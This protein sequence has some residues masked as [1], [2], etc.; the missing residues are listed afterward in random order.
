MSL[1]FQ[2]PRASNAG[3]P[4]M[5][6]TAVEERE[7]LQKDRRPG[8]ATMRMGRTADMRSGDWKTKIMMPVSSM[9]VLMASTPRPAI[10]QPRAFPS[11]S[12]SRIPRCREP[13]NALARAAPVRMTFGKTFFSNGS[14]ASTR[15]AS[16]GGQLPHGRYVKA[17]M[18]R[19]RG[20]RER[21]HQ[22][23][24]EDGGHGAKCALPTLRNFTGTADRSRRVAHAQQQQ[25]RG[26]AAAAADP[27]PHRRRI[28]SAPARGLRFSIIRAAVEAARREIQHARRVTQ[29]R[30][31][32][33]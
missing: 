2:L 8:E 6:Y 20:P 31:W 19:R 10:H 17:P 22:L 24:Q 32:V 23:P 26:Q 1:E 12:R 28:A 11:R 13:L 3:N 18:G 4:Y 15:S 25:P 21:A 9:R 33:S 14:L 5:F 7:V 16:P 29:M 27:G 30:S